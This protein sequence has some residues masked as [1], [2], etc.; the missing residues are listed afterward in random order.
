MPMETAPKSLLCSAQDSARVG[1][2]ALSRVGAALSQRSETKG[3][4]LR[5]FVRKREMRRVARGLRWSLCPALQ[6][7]LLQGLVACSQGGQEALAV[8]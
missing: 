3:S 5:P 8:A 6:R 2:D 4:V 7:A 1:G